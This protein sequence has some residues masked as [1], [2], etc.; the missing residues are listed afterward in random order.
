MSNE[1]QTPAAAAEPASPL[2]SLMQIPEGFSV[3]GA[4]ML[5]YPHY[6]YKRLPDRNPLQV[7]W[8]D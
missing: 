3:V 8:V 5:G 7:T 4:M 6:T 1:N 2:V